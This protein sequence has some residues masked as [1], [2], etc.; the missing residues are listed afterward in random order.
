MQCDADLIIAD[1]NYKE[2]SANFDTPEHAIE[3]THR[4]FESLKEVKPE[5]KLKGKI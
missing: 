5:T 2:T 3:W 1:G 4:L